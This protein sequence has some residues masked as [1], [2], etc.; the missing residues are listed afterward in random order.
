VVVMGGGDV[1]INAVKQRSSQQV[2][3][4]LV[5]PRIAILQPE[6]LFCLRTTSMIDVSMK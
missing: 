6:I 2:V 3:A 5:R 1:S 4:E